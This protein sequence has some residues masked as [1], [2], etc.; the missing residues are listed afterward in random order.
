MLVF[1]L[2]ELKLQPNGG[3]GLTLMALEDGE[4]LTGVTGFADAVRVLGTGRGGKPRDEMV[5]GSALASHTQKRA[6]KGAKVEGVLKPTQLL[7]GSLG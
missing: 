5:K 4:T 2:A 7:P 1:G 3:K 6:R